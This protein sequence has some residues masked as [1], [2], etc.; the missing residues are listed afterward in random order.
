MKVRLKL[1]IDEM[2]ALCWVLVQISCLDTYNKQ[3]FIYKNEAMDLYFKLAEKMRNS[4]RKHYSVQ[5]NSIQILMLFAYDFAMGNFER[6]VYMEICAK[7]DKQ[8]I[9]DVHH[10]TYRLQ[11]PKNELLE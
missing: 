11:A 3:E 8:Y 1:T 9:S 4:Y 7:I 10:R 2:K 5:L 6:V